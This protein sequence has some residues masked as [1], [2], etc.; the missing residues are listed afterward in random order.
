MDIFTPALIGIGLSMDCFAVSLAIGTNIRT[1]LISAAVI[2]ALSFGAFQ[3]GMTLIGWAAGIW[4]T[5]F[6]AVFGSWIAFILLALVGGKMLWEGIEGDD[7]NEGDLD[8]IRFLPV[9]V[10]SF[11]TSIDALAAG[12]SFGLLQSAILIPS[13][14]IGIISFGFSFGGVLFGRHLLGI[15]GKKT[16]ILGGF[17]LIMIGLN[18]L[19]GHPFW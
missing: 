14:I 12:I 18:I 15:L 9:L 8:V 10:L 6:V 5:G 2:I 17:I 1:R 3:A 11:A 4:V 16:E 19:L 13:L 7:D